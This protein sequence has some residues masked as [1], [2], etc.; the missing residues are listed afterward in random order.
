[1]GETAKLSRFGF[2]LDLFELL[3]NSIISDSPK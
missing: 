2:T 3:W 1:M